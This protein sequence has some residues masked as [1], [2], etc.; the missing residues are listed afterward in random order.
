MCTSATL[1]PLSWSE[2]APALAAALGDYMN[3]AKTQTALGNEFIF[4]C[5]GAVMLLRAE[6]R[7]LVI[8]GFSG[9]HR[10]ATAAPAIVATA[11]AI[12]ATSLRVHTT[13]RGELRY[14]NMLGY[15]FRLA[16][17]RPDNHEYVLRMTI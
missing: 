11:K 12:G 9:P 13:R 2:A 8:V 4:G 16:E 5:H 17:T 7:E 3:D 15:P 6:G 1:K 14:L 10:L